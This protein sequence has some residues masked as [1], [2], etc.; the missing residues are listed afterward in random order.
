MLPRLSDID[1]CCQSQRDS[2]YLL[3]KNKNIELGS[4]TNSASLDFYWNPM[5]AELDILEDLL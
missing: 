1:T 4:A 5:S 2:G 3:I